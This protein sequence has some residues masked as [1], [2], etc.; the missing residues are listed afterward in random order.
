MN[1]AES[2]KA[3]ASNA[4]PS[5]STKKGVNQKGQQYTLPKNMIIAMKQTANQYVV[6]S[7]LEGED[8]TEFNVL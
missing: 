4:G 6:L 3:C 7:D 8:R 5:K 1:N 2:S